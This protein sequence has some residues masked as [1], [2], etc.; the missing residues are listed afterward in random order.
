MV[1]TVWFAQYS[2]RKTKTHL[3]HP[4]D[5]FGVTMI[6]MAKGN[7]LVSIFWL[8]QERFHVLVEPWLP[9]MPNGIDLENK[10]RYMLIHNGGCDIKRN[11]IRS[12]TVLRTLSVSTTSVMVPHMTT[13]FVFEKTMPSTK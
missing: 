7:V 1:C 6:V 11:N 2:E 5:A 8:R 10:T 13:A 4:K 9:V 12:A 3:Q